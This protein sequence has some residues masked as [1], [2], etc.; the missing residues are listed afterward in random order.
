MKKD[1]GFNGASFMALFGVVVL[2]WSEIW[3]VHC[4][5]G[6]HSLSMVISEHLTQQVKGFFRN[7]LIVLGVNE[8]L[9]CFA[10]L[11]PDDVVVVAVKGHVVLLYV[12][13]EFVCAQNLCDLDQLIVVVFSLEEGFLLED[14]SC[15][16]ASK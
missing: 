11:L 5:T 8:L 2:H 15:E 13:E 3:V 10:W 4:I 7:E 16:H 6:S 9:P 1:G 12:R 14:H